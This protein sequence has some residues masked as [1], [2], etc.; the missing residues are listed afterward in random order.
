MK[1]IDWLVYFPGSVP[2]LHNDK[3]H[4]SSSEDH[5]HPVGPGS[6]YSPDQPTRMRPHEHRDCFVPGPKPLVAHS[7]RHIIQSVIR[8]SAHSF[9]AVFLLADAYSTL[10][11]ISA[12]FSSTG[13][14][15]SCKFR[16][17]RS[18]WEHVGKREAL[19]IF[20]FW[21]VALWH[22]SKPWNKYLLPSDKWKILAL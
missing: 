20:T 14:P 10:Q 2:W 4:R 8:Q 13:T 1:V 9:H 15:N 7:S 19:S 17:E 3:G 5:E 21:G 18:L 6:S 12:T 16:A 22:L 11:P